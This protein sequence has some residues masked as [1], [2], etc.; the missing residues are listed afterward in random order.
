MTWKPDLTRPDRVVLLA[1]HHDDETLFASFLAL[2]HRP[3]LVICTRADVQEAR[4]LPITHAD[5]EA[6][7]RAAWQI[8]STDEQ[9]MVQWAY[10]D[11]ESKTD[12]SA[13]AAAIARLADVYDRVIAPAAEPVGGHAHHDAVGL[14]A[15]EAFG[16]SRTIRYLTYTRHEG[17]ST[18]GH[19]VEIKH[20]DW[21]LAKLRALACYPTQIREKTTRP[22]FLEPLA[23]YQ[24]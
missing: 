6:E 20:P 2:E 5:R 19:E 13:L 16:D 15:L 7:T 4:G 21:I 9:K 14:A 17:R 23:E 10:S 8:L 3:D 1:P 12:W 11:I 22:W 18:W 24:A